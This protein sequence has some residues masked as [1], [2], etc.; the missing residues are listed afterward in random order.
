[1]DDEKKE[2]ITGNNSIHESN[3]DNNY[4]T[5]NNTNNNNNSRIHTSASSLPEVI[6]FEDPNKSFKLY[7]LEKPITKEMI[8]LKFFLVLSGIVMMTFLNNYNVFFTS[9]TECFWDFSHQVLFESLNNY[10]VNNTAAKDGLEIIG[11]LFVDITVLC[12]GFY[13]SWKGNSWRLLISMS[14]FYGIR[15]IIQLI[16][17]MCFPPN[18]IFSYPGFPSLF[19]SYLKTNDFFYSGHVGFPILCAYELRRFRW[20]IVFICYF[21]S[22]YEGFILMATRGHYDIDCYFGWFIVFYIIRISR[23]ICLWL[24]KKVFIG[25]EDKYPKIFKDLNSTP[26]WFPN[27]E[28]RITDS[29]L[30]KSVL[31][32]NEDN[33]DDDNKEDEDIFIN[34]KKIN[35]DYSMELP[36]VKANKKIIDNNKDYYNEEEIR[37]KK[38]K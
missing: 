28:N 11:G 19:V 27:K 13:F 22:V 16:Y 26:E 4:N 32:L 17:Q 15:A 34:T 20:W 36:S 21:V 23:W 25:N 14:L 24:D 29:E 38:K 31:N 1:M 3:N 8:I 33:N 12:T 10:L 30:D 5:N 37:I 35:K 9:Y 2:L 18:D 7:F 6:M